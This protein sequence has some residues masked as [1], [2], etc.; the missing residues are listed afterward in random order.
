MMK[1]S[2]HR[3]FELSASRQLNDG[4]IHGNNFFGW[5]GVSGPID[6]YTGMIVNIVGL[7]KAINQV[8][9]NYDHRFLNSQL[10][11]Q[12]PTTLN[13]ACVIW[14]D[15]AKLMPEYAT[16][17]I[18]QLQEQDED[19]VE[20]TGTTQSKIHIG[21]FS[22][23]HRTHAPR[24][25][26]AANQALFGICNNPNG[27]G[28][29]YQVEV[30]TSPEFDVSNKIWMELDHRN[31]SEDVL[32]LQ[33][34]NVVTE[35]IAAYISEKVSQAKKVRVWETSDFYAE[36]LSMPQVYRLGRK[37]R[38]HAAHRLNSNYFSEA[39]NQSI[40]GKCNRL[41]PHGHTYVVQVSVQG[42]LDPASETAYDINCMDQAAEKILNE[43]DYKFLDLDIPYFLDHTSTGENIVHYLYNQ[44]ESQLQQSLVEVRLWETPKN[45]FIAT[46]EGVLRDERQW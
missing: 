27:H 15:L 22:A 20:L 1:I 10:N 30:I 25:S 46:K 2:T 24:L 19:A 11:G 35:T 5:A 28:H 14:A 38:F 42:E 39:E 23:A 36:Y 9:D 4:R 43:L 18:L 12:E 3:R 7:K 41:D 32:E 40:F 33:N 6:P 26:K 44:F 34:H 29:N 21:T 17:N 13:L 16:L 37:Y 8:L 31:L 45:L